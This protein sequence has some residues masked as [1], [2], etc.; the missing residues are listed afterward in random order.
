MSRVFSFRLDD[1]NPREAQ[2]KDTIEN[3]KSK[4]YSLRFVITEAL[5]SFGETENNHDSFSRISE[6]LEGVLAILRDNRDNQFEDKELS[7]A[8]VQSLKKSVKSGVRHE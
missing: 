7:R 1:D 8:F 4:G 2:A 5:L 3:W 6:E